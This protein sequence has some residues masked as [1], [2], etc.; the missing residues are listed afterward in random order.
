MEL[1]LQCLVTLVTNDNILLKSKAIIL[2][3]TYLKNPNTLVT[4]MKFFIYYILRS[5]YLLAS[6]LISV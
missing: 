5:F 3:E 2:L 4:N 6:P 1:F